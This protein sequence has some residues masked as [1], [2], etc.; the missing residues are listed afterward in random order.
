MKIDLQRFG[1]DGVE[2]NPDTIITFPGG[3]LGFG[4]SKR[5]KLFHEEGKPTV[6]WL[7]SVDDPEL[8]VSVTDPAN[9]QF[10]Y[11]ITLSDEE[12]ASLQAKDASDLAVLL[13]VYRAAEEQGGKVGANVRAPLVINLA[14]RIGLQ[15]MLQDIDPVITFRSK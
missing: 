7:Q 15:K 13:V 14:S 2:I 4:E 5:Y 10:S 11:E 9:F 1:L 12:S 6:H 3:L 8:M